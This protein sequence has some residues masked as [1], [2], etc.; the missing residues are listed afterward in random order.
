MFL[1]TNIKTRVSRLSVNEFGLLYNGLINL[2]NPG[3]LS[4]LWSGLED[5]AKQMLV[6]KSDTDLLG[7][8]ATELNLPY[9]S[10]DVVEGFD[11]FSHISSEIKNKRMVIV[12]FRNPT[13]HTERHACVAYKVNEIGFFGNNIYVFNPWGNDIVISDF[14]SRYFNL[15]NG[16]SKPEMNWEID[17][18]ITF[19]Y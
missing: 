15:N 1:D 16:T 17:S 11:Y 5:E 6:Q 2:A 4:A 10:T 8:M 12:I 7:T 13:N 18:Y 9:I 14:P 3:D 19:N